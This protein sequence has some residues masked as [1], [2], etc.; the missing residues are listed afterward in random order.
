MIDGDRNQ[1]PMVYACFIS[2]LGS[3]LAVRDGRDDAPVYTKDPS[4]KT[5]ISLGAVGFIKTVRRVARLFVDGRQ[6]QVSSIDVLSFSGLD[7]FGCVQGS[8]IGSGIIYPKGD[9]CAGTVHVWGRL[10]AE[11]FRFISCST[12]EPKLS[13][14]RRSRDG[15]VRRRQ[16]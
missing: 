8:L 9:P 6:S 14:G 13:E 3:K 4:E 7:P 15:K 10:D 2:S 11:G 1:I 16:R 12:S 5:V